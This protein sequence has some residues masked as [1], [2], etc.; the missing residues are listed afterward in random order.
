MDSSTQDTKD[1]QRSA[2]FWKSFQELENEV[3]LE[4]NP[5][6]KNITS[7]LVRRKNLKRGI[8]CTKS[9]LNKIIAHPS[10]KMFTPVDPRLEFELKATPFWRE[11]N[12]FE[13]LIKNAHTSATYLGL[14]NTILFTHGKEGLDRIQE[15][16]DLFKRNPNNKL[17][18]DL[19]QLMCKASND[20]KH[21]EEEKLLHMKKEVEVA[22]FDFQSY[23]LQQKVFYS[24][25]V[26]I[27]TTR[28][29]PTTYIKVYQRREY[30]AFVSIGEKLYLQTKHATKS[31]SNSHTTQG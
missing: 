13:H 21:I 31:K 23:F 20:P 5:A 1:L 8:T 3:L 27:D 14:A 29:V 25:N 19:L 28:L 22:L 2:S 30:Q 12:I 6:I 18:L 11:W 7:N 24:Y 15:L 16:E 10:M 4:E 9:D 17:S 26:F